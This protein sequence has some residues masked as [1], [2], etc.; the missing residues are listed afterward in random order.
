MLKVFSLPILNDNYV[1]IPVNTETHECLFVDPGVAGP[2]KDFVLR[3]QLQP[4][5]IFL[6][7]HHWDHIGGAQEL[8][9]SFSVQTYAPLKEAKLIDFADKYLVEND[10][11]EVLGSRFQVL[12]LSGHTRGQIGYWN[13]E[14]KWLFCGDAL[15]S[16]G[17][18]R[19][20]DGSI[21][22]HYQSLSK[23][24]QLPPDTQIFCTHEYTELNL[25]F[26]QQ[27]L[28]QDSALDS[29]AQKVGELRKQHQPT[30]PFLL[31]QE[32]ELN[33]FLKVNS[34]EEFRQLREKRDRF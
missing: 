17:C 22:A 34:L 1:H 32:L 21:E 6:T 33:P 4:R 31:Q 15:F 24:R 8:M 3:Q 28:P 9:K 14:A 18:G 25:R 7:H 23:I 11:L 29:F 12:D 13:P 2:V 26:C 19:V 10:V 27:E 20:F 16:L 5:N 30:V